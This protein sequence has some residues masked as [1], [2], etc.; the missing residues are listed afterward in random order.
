MAQVARYN[1]LSFINLHI[2]SIRRL[3]PL[4]SIPKISNFSLNKDL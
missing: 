2:A 1:K 3:V 4:R